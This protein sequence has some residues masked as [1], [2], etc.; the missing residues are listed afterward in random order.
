MA[1]R[2]PIGA[3]RNPKSPTIG[4]ICSTPISSDMSAAT[5][6]QLS[7]PVTIHEL[8]SNGLNNLVLS[9]G[10]TTSTRNSNHNRLGPSEATRNGTRTAEGEV[11]QETE[12]VEQDEAGV[13]ITLT[14][15][16]GG[17]KD[18]KRVRFS[19]RRF[20]EKQAEQWWAENRARVY[21]QYNV[22]MVDKSSIGI[23][24]EA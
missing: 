11:S 24:S 16:P 20:S 21:E 7:S 9:S 19:R 12:W 18:L 22:R 8:D 5:L 1:E 17:V 4:S 3:M 23:G 10:P 14:S 13:Y 15:L 2:L 6:D